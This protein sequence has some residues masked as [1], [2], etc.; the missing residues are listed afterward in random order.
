VVWGSAATPDGQPVVWGTACPSTTL[1]TGDT[2]C[3]PSTELG[4]IV[5]GTQ[6]SD[7]NCDDENIVWGTE[8]GGGNCNGENIVWGTACGP[9]DTDPP[10]RLGTGCDNIVWGTA[11]P[12][13]NIVWGTVQAGFNIVWGTNVL[14]DTDNVVWG[15]PA[16]RR[17]SRILVTDPALR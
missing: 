7:K 4:N 5:W 3:G 16:F 10:T 11:E 1:E 17:R 13:F 2:A 15:A 6:C 14:D 9:A 8:C 12:G